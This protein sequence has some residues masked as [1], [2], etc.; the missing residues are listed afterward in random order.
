MLFT[1]NFVYVPH[2]NAAT[3]Y[4]NSNSQ[5]DVQAAIDSAS[6]GDRVVIPNGGSTWST[7]I[8]IN[9]SITLQGG[10]S[11]SVNTNHEDNGSWPLTITF[12]SLPDYRSGIE[13]SG[14][15]GTFIR[16]TG[17]HFTGSVPG[18]TSGHG[19]ILV[20]TSNEANWRVDNCKFNVSGN[21]LTTQSSGLGGL[22]D[23][24]Y[25]YSSGCDT[26]SRVIA[27]D[28]RNS[29]EGNWAF[30]QPVGFGSSNFLFIE[31][32]TFW[33]TCTSG[34]P[35]TA[36]T[37]AQAGG[38][39]VFRH[40]YVKD[41]MLIWHG[42]ES[43]APQRGGYAFEIY[44]NEFYWTMPSWKYH[45]A[46]FDRGGTA[47]VYNNIATNYHALW[48]TWVHRAETPFGIFGQADGNQVHDGNWGA[49]YPPGYPALDQPGR[50]QA[51]GVA[52]SD[53]QPQQESKCYIWNNTLIN[54]DAVFHNNPTYVVE[55]RD[56]EISSDDS[57]KPSGY[58]SYP[59]PHPLQSS[60][61]GPNPPTNLRLQ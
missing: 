7:P 58:I 42:S 14:T 40:N 54:T 15:L 47:L 33:K 6:N 43:G 25:S 23:H 52:L 11:Y 32:S 46:I 12:S 26:D 10:G 51:S 16:I 1:Y 29:F 9:K 18:G 21:A 2:A 37:D 48:K 17:I 61:S 55:G 3:I 56:Y 39:F 34:T 60:G 41:A 30:T 38:K 27:M 20:E 45:A 5:Q 59:Y 22:V 24:I 49:P 4:A 19:A 36:V 35:S 53:V 50:G 13:I 8:T 31:D 57:A 44:N 28:N